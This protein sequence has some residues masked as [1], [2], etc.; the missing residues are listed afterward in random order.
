MSLLEVSAFAV[1]FSKTDAVWLQDWPPIRRENP[2]NVTMMQMQL[3]LQ[4][5]SDIKMQHFLNLGSMPE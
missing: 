4:A 3:I 5:R 1:L 2:S